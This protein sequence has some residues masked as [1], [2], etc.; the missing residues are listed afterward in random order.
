MQEIYIKLIIGSLLHDIGKILFRYND[1]RN[2]SQSGGD[3]LQNEIKIEDPD[4]LDQVRFHHAEHLKRAKVKD[5]SLAYVTYIADNISSAVDRRKNSGEE[6]GFDRGMALESIFN[7]LNGNDEEFFYRAEQLEKGINYP[8]DVSIGFNEGFYGKIVRHIQDSLNGIQFTMEYINSLLEIL[9]ADLSFVPSSTMKG[10]VGDISLFDH[11]KLTAAFSVCIAA[12]L[13]QGN[14]VVDYKQ[15][16]FINTKQFYSKK[17]FLLFSMDMS[18]IQDF[19]YT[20]ASKDALKSLRSRSFYLEMLMEHL[21]DELLEETEMSRANLL[22]SGGGHAYLIL[23][24]TNKIKDKLQKFE[25]SVNTWLLKEFHTALYLGCAY[26]EC[27]A[28]ALHNEP[29]GSYRKIFQSVSGKISEKKAHRYEADELIKMNFMESSET[30]RECK[31]C[32]RSDHLN[33]EDICYICHSLVQMSPY[34]LYKGFFVIVNEPGEKVY[35]PMPDGHFMIADS[36]KN[37]LEQM[38][39]DTGNYIRSYVKNN[40]YSGLNV[41]KRLWIG[42]Y[43]SGDTFEELAS[44]SIGINR[45]AV[46]RADVDNLG[47]AFVNGFVSEK[48]GERYMT[49]SRTATFSRKMSMFF[50][51]HINAILDQGEYYITEKREPGKRKITIVYSGGDDLFV[52]GSWDE[53]IG[54]AVDLYDA[55]SEFTQRTLSI[56]A[57]IGIYPG[58]YPIHNMAA[59]TGEL[60]ACAKQNPGKNAVTL[61]EDSLTFGWDDFENDVLETKLPFLKDFFDQFPKKGKAYL[62]RMLDLI[63]NIDDDKINLAR[64]AYAM[65]RLEDEMG[66]GEADIRFFSSKIYKWIQEKASRKALIAAIYLYV[67]LNREED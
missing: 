28:N 8:S 24:N 65:A 19:I 12:Y 50:K 53:V 38:K 40:A 9:E 51:Y 42:D 20:I 46:L 35:L 30:V 48:Y 25:K 26:E 55:F 67:Y 21:I 17:V 33:E 66:Q 62:Y 16:L 15:E 44:E 37:L 32:R 36:Q 47:T 49:I 56:S 58:K 7:L 45:I 57:G 6:T 63:R 29:E 2:H 31:V 54:F 5:D 39:K 11:V 10:E 41:A 13:Q 64:L 14:E 52:V 4:I 22:Y 1:G 59:R 60:E 18:G 3:F 23:P 43:T 61:F 34:I 27:S